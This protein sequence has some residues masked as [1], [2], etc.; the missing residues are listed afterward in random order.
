[1]CPNR[2]LAIVE[3]M[4]GNHILDIVLIVVASVFFVGAGVFLPFW[5]Y[6]QGRGTRRPRGRGHRD[7]QHGVAV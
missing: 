1:M 3:G 5:E 6:T 7:H 2:D 4:T